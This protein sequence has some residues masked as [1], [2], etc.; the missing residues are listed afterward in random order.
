MLLYYNSLALEWKLIIN[1]LIFN[2]KETFPEVLI[3]TSTVETFSRCQTS[4]FGLRRKFEITKFKCSI[5]RNVRTIP[6]NTELR[7]KLS[8]GIKTHSLFSLNYLF[9]CKNYAFLIN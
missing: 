2:F 4:V 5:F 1:N 8:A 7:Q 3:K 6:Q 9:I